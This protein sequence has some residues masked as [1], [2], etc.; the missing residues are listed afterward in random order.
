MS[1]EI[2]QTVEGFNPGSKES[3]SNLVSLSELKS[4]LEQ[5]VTTK[6]LEEY[7]SKNY[8]FTVMDGDVVYYV[9]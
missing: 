9:N 6:N 4:I 1:K 5:M 7:I 3:F 2:I 8:T